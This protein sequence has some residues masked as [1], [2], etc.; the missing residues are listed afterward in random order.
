[1]AALDKVQKA[2]DEKRIDTRSLNEEQIGAL[3]DAFKS[4]ELT[5][6]E[7]V[8]QYE[9]LIDLGAMSVAQGKMKRLKPMES[10]TGIGR[11]DMVLAGT[12]GFGMLPYMV[13]R[14]ALISSYVKNGFK[15]VYGVDNRYVAGASIYD[16]RLS[17]MSKFAKKLKKVPGPLGIPVRLLGNTIGVLDNT[18]DFFKKINKFGPS[19]ALGVEAKSALGAIGGAFGGS[20]TYD[21]ANLGSDFVG[22]TSK[23]L[24]ELTDSDERK[25]PFTERM[26]LNGLRASRDEMLWTGGAL[27]LLGVVRSAGRGLKSSLDLDKAQ[28]KEIAAAAERSGQ[29]VNIVDLI[30]A[31]NPGLRGA[32]QSFTKKFFTTLGVYPLVG[33]PLKD[34]NRA[35]NA[36]LTQEQF[37][38]TMDNLD[39][40][41]MV[42]NSI[43][44]YAGVNQ[45]KNEFKN[46]WKTIDDEY[47]RFRNHYEQLG[48]PTFIPTTNIR[49]TT[50]TIL[51]RLKTEYPEQYNIWDGL[52]KGAKDLTP[53]DD[54]MVQYIKYLNRISE[55]SEYTSKGGYVRLSDMLGLSKMLTKAYSGS[56][57][58][59]VDNEV[60]RL[61]KAFE[62][63]VNSLGEAANR[64][65]LKDKIFKDEYQMKLTQEGPEA[66]EAFLDT[67]INVANS[68]L[69][70]L[71]E[72]NAYYSMVLRPYEK[73]SVARKLMAVDRKLFASKGI[74]M[75]GIESI[76]PDQVFDKVIKGTLAGDSPLAV[77]Q[78]KQIL[79][80]TDSSYDILKADGSIDRTVKIPISKESQAVW[81]RY[82]K[83]WL[84][85]SVNNSTTNPIRDLK[86]LSAQAIAAQAKKKGLI[87]K[88][89]NP[90]DADVE[91][92]VRA[93]TRTDEVSNVTEVDARI[94]TEGDGVANLNEGLIR[95]HDFGSL[96]IDK[97]VR[98]LGIDNKQGKDKIREIF[99][100]GA[101]GDRALKMFE[102]II[103]V[104]K[105]M[106]GV[107][108]TDP[109]KFIQRSL[110]LRAGSGQGGMTATAVT[111][112]VL[113][114]GNTLKLML[115]A[116]LF[117][118]IIGTAKIAENVM[119]MNK[120]YRFLLNADANS[121]FPGKGRIPLTP[122]LYNGALLTTGRAVNSL[123][124]AMGDD[125]RVDPNKI[126]FEEIRQKLM[127]LDPNV[128]LGNSYDFGSMSKFT[129][130]RIYP[131]Y[132]VVK[133][134][135]PD[136]R[137]AGEEY[138]QGASIMGA[139]HNQ[140]QEI[141]NSNPLMQA[142]EAPV[143]TPAVEPIT[144]QSPQATMPTATQPAVN[145][146]E[147]YATLFPQD[148]LG[149]ALANRG[150][151]Q[152]FNEGGLVE[153][154]YQMAEEVLN[155]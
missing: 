23:D 67:N 139:S 153:D 35:F 97:F 138:L 71:Q 1:M 9:K 95:N 11:G 59:V 133:M 45:I 148:T 101:K 19:T 79:G 126:D 150:N 82:I 130:D 151:T 30:P 7:S 107:P 134:L 127:S 62:N 10:S 72:A 116:R 92:R 91:Q 53:A 105:A 29:K 132:D 43:L 118:E 85:D 87:R 61:K 152:Q 155:A 81:D 6:Y 47:G 99:G 58:K 77:K 76:A 129:R 22:A 149:Q 70:Q 2:I 28:A 84:W 140:F 145:Q 131:E 106:E 96:D 69:K 51:E 34:F 119:E 123:F 18:V 147:Q 63:D 78:L 38:K 49:N 109:A 56:Q 8:G 50:K 36:D 93:K 104:K 136:M 12:V 120:A 141:M 39:L 17:Q 64:D 108:S 154:A 74:D 26:F 121:I 75:T 115:T 98:K 100:G 68:A 31:D 20:A 44:N 143:N 15:D 16:K 90:L 83:Q 144:E 103:E 111:G 14:E 113:G 128:P 37:I 102:D 24:A 46:V 80:V 52:E 146:G 25:L 117:G 60:I 42:N 66:A 124:E 86:G 110:T 122:K 137:R 21:I 89:F 27:G 57:F 114:I 32:W 73:S 112:A 125:F 135:S 40:P 3:D 55:T 94:F 65:I 48:N 54:P 5:G 142:A 13:E 88:N 33:Q 41:P 4:G